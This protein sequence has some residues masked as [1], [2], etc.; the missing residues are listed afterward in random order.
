[1]ADDKPQPN[2]VKE[3]PAADDDGRV[4]PFGFYG[5]GQ[6]APQTTHETRH[7]DPQVVKLWSIYTQ[8]GNNSEDWTFRSRVIACAKRLFDQT[9]NWFTMQDR[10]R[11]V[12][13]YNHLFI[14]DT[15]RF[16][17][18]G[19]RN[20]NIHTW[21]DLVSY[22]PDADNGDYIRR[23][24]GIAD[25]IRDLSIDTKTD[26]I[27]QNWCKRPG[28]FDDMMCSLNILFGDLPLRV[29]KTATE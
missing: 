7:G 6:A 24:H 16:I 21:P 9:P 4:Y 13:E 22:Y 12:Q 27:L 18:T 8:G 19:R 29:S 25:Q 11:F 2:A 3:R 10:N 14:I 23:R 1:M 5:G 26:A 20:I 17:A 15:L 28:G